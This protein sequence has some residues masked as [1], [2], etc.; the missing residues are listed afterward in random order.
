M[1]PSSRPKQKESV[2]RNALKKAG[3]DSGV[4]IVGIRG[5]YLD[6]MGEVGKNDRGIYDDA[7]IVVSDNVHASFNANTDPSIFRKGIASLKTGLH[8]YKKGKHGISRGPGYP[9]LRPAAK[10]E[11]LPV[12]R[13]GQGDSFGIAI[14]IHKGGY[15]TTSSEGCQTIYPDQWQG[16]I[17]LVYCEMERFG[18]KTIP[19]LLLE[20]K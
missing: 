14:N 13:D 2:T 7:I 11:A 20:N 19:Y 18:Q 16:F 6:T 10:D 8:L 4:A 12:T 5:Y 17:N 1:V 15:K 9:A 3:I